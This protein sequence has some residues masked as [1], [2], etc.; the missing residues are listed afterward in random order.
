MKSKL[1]RLKDIVKNYDVVTD[2]CGN[3]IYHATINDL[4]CI[5]LDIPNAYRILTDQD[6]ELEEFTY[7]MKKGTLE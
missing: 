3:I 5:I 4:G 2:S 1:E 7:Y 6:F